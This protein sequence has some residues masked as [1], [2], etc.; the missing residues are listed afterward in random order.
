MLLMLN[1]GMIYRSQKG[2][3]MLT[4]GGF[5]LLVWFVGCLAGVLLA[6]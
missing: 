3:G 1:L 6:F 5:L 2:L 4:F